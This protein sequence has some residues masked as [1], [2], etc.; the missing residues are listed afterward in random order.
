MKSKGL[1]Y[2]R[3]PN[4]FKYNKKIILASINKYINIFKYIPN[5]LTH[6]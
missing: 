1:F 4:I 6:D 3:I 2:N 5:N